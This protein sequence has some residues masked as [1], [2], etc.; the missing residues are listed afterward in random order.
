MESAR[1]L[2][3]WR[4]LVCGGL[5]CRTFSDHD[6]TIKYSMYRPGLATSGRTSPRIPL[7]HDT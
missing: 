7:R 1:A 4:V 3:S 5:C 6:S 2:K